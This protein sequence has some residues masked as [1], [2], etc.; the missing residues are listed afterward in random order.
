VVL[1]GTRG[2]RVVRWSVGAGSTRPDAA[3]LGHGPVRALAKYD[4]GAL[5][6]TQ[7]GAI[8]DIDELLCVRAVVHAHG[9]PVTG[10]QVAPGGRRVVS[11]GGD[12]SAR[13]WHRQLGA[14]V[15]ERTLRSRGDRCEATA[16]SRDGRLCAVITQ[17]AT[18]SVFDATEGTLR[19]ARRVGSWPLRSVV[20]GAAHDVV[21]GDDWGRVTRLCL[22]DGHQVDRAVAAQHGVRDLVRLPHGEVLAVSYDGSASDVTTSQPVEVLRLMDQRPRRG[23]GAAR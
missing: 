8:L 10:L 21:V 11:T 20:F 14:L 5:V 9:G 2:G 23:A 4:G 7:T 13:T 16:I 19:W 6:G 12:G 1:A 15:F 3:S 22:T 18:V 17:D